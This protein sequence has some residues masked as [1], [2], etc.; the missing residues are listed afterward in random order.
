MLFACIRVAAVI[1]SDG[2]CACVCVFQKTQTQRDRGSARLASVW[3]S[4]R[5]GSPF[6]TSASLSEDK[7]QSLLNREA[8]FGDLWVQ[9]RQEYVPRGAPE[10]AHHLRTQYANHTLT[11]AFFHCIVKVTPDFCLKNQLYPP[12]QET[13]ILR[14]ISTGMTAGVIYVH[15]RGWPG[16]VVF[17]HFQEGTL[18]VGGPGSFYWQGKP[19]NSASVLGFSDF[20]GWKLLRGEAEMSLT[21]ITIHTN[22]LAQGHRCTNQDFVTRLFHVGRKKNVFFP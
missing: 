20:I 3:I 4:L 1:W 19:K 22:T 11:H 5:W 21:A 9:R 8:P 6:V 17:L 2:S 16:I 13:V 10:V 14:W 12:V 18:V 15:T 7:H